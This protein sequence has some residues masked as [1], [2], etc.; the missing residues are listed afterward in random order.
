DEKFRRV[1][2]TSTSEYKDYGQSWSDGD[3]ARFMKYRGDDVVRSVRTAI[4]QF[5]AQVAARPYA[6]RAFAMPPT[7][8]ETRVLLGTGAHFVSPADEGSARRRRTNLSGRAG[9]TSMGRALAAI[10]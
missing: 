8:F 1:V 6:A 4:A 7:E 2:A 10:M 9:K 3:A 5:Y